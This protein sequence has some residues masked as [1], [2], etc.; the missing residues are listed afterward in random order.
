[1][2][3][4][5]IRIILF[6]LFFALIGCSKDSENTTDE[7]S[8]YTISCKVNGTTWNSTN[9]SGAINDKN[10][11]IADAFLLMG[12]SVVGGDQSETQFNVM[13]Q[14]GNLVAGKTITIKGGFNGGEFIGLFY[15][16]KDYVTN[17]GPA[18][19]N[20]GVITI[21]SVGNKLTGT[22]NGTLYSETGET[23]S[24]TEGTFNV[25]LTHF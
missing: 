1:M 25:P 5:Q 8:I 11:P 15:N 6:A 12:G 16:N 10:K 18:N 4:K 14:G 21:N 17:N 2:K 7:N 20:L 22:F 19:T 13:L 3:T 9:G 23:I 24:V